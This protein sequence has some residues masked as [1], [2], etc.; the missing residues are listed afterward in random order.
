MQHSGPSSASETER[1]HRTRWEALSERYLSHRPDLGIWRYNRDSNSSDIDQ[2]WKLHVSATIL[3]ACD[4]LESIADTL[5]GFGVQFKAPIDL[6]V[7]GRINSGLGR[8]YSQVGKFIT[9]YPRTEDE[10]VRL[11][12]EL[13]RLTNGLDYVSVPFE[14]QIA[15][16]SNVH[17]RFGAFISVGSEH[18]RLANTYYLIGPDGRHVV[19]DR[20]VAIPD[21]V[22][23]P[24]PDSERVELTDTS[25]SPFRNSFLVIRAISQRG[26]G[27][28]Y[29]AIDIR[30]KENP[31][32]C[33]VKEGRIHGEQQWNGADGR[34][35]LRNEATV[36]S[37]LCKPGIQVPKVRAMFGR[38]CNEYA[39]IDAIEG[40]SIFELIRRRR[41]R[42]PVRT[43]VEISAK[44][45]DLISSIHR[46]GWVWNDCK[47]ANLIIAPDGR[48]F[49]IDFENSFPIDGV[50]SFDWSSPQ[51]S[52][53]NLDGV[54][55]DIYGLAATMYFLLTGVFF[56]PDDF[57]P[58]RKLRRKIS[59]EL[60][61]AVES[62]L[63]SPVGLRSLFERIKALSVELG[64]SPEFS[65][66][67]LG[68]NLCEKGAV[69]G[70]GEV[71]KVLLA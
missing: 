61:D 52:T 19:D 29:E 57:V 21:W 54:D 67:R 44:A 14:R 62:A 49:A 68:G 66:G 17:F 25:D 28:T 33:I 4:V 35:L 34:D 43:V 16:K 60:A 53:A 70:A 1:L 58:I 47:P 7:L 23:C 22:N 15:D 5:I 36:L 38:K 69:D 51:Y 9:V 65:K 3:S 59:L 31:S 20:M 40:A 55:R 18:G 12:Y 71:V 30:D 6:S 10:A 41:R 63:H 46:V 24:F 27:G 48:L 45:V 2:G 64:A 26:K 13:N 32:R 50:A 37:A 8:S 56:E 39:V 42:L 11:A